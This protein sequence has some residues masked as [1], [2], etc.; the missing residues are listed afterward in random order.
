MKERAFRIL[1]A[2]A[3][4]AAVGA[5]VGAG[6]PGSARSSG[7]ADQPGG[8]TV[9]G[10]GTV[11]T[12]PDRASLSF[13]VTTQATTAS[14]ALARNS[15]AMQKVIAALKAHGV[16]AA[17]LQTQSI[18]LSPRATDKGEIV[19]Y[20]ASNAVSVQS[21]IARAGE[22]ID[23]AVGAGA[24]D[25]SGP[26][27]TRSDQDALYRQALK[28]AVADAKAKAQALAAAAGVTLGSVTAIVEGSSSPQPIA[29]GKTDTNPSTPIE[30]G[31]QQIQASVTVVF[32]VS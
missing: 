7:T 9:N 4:A 31:T 25:V 29:F 23:A 14:A 13:G 8:I 5:L 19:G 28:N 22:L 20:T 2:G 30:P 16:A 3:L 15:E 11:T 18:S 26:T 32:A 6:S 10:N 21:A 27:F 17:D 12:T 1:A 24:T